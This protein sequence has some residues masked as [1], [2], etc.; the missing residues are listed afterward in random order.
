MNQ[1]IV[2]DI[3][4]DLIDHTNAALKNLK[5]VKLTEKESKNVASL[6]QN[7]ISKLTQN[8]LT[9]GVVGVMKAG[10]STFINSLIGKEILPSRTL[11]MT[12]IPTKIQ[13]KLISN[14]EVEYFFSLFDEY[15][16]F[17][18]WLSQ[19]TILDRIKSG[20]IAHKVDPALLDNLTSGSLRVVQTANSLINAQE[21]LFIVNDLAR[22]NSWYLNNYKDCPIDLLENI[23]NE[24]DIPTLYV[25]FNALKDVSLSNTAIALID[26]P[27]PDEAGQNMALANVLK[28]VLTNASAVYCVINGK[29]I[30]DL[31][32]EEL[33]RQ[34]NTYKNV[35]S[36]RLELIVNQKD[37]IDKGLCVEDVIL[38][39]RTFGDFDLKNKIH[40]L[41]SKSA[42]YCNLAIANADDVESNFE[43]YQSNSPKW[44]DE[45]SSLRGGSYLEDLEDELDEGKKLSKV[46]IKH[47]NRMHSKSGFDEFINNSLV[48]IYKKSSFDI[49][50][51]AIDTF[52]SKLD[53]DDSA[54]V[55]HSIR[56]QIH[57]FE[58]GKKE[59]SE[60]N[61]AMELN[62][63]KILE[64]RQKTHEL[65]DVE[66]KD[67]NYLAKEISSLII[68]GDDIGR[69]DKAHQCY[70]KIESII[71]TSSTNFSNESNAQSKL[72]SIKKQLS[73]SLESLN[74]ELN[75]ISKN[76]AEERISRIN[77]VISNDL[78][79]ILSTIK[80]T[81]EEVIDWSFDIPTIQEYTSSI[82]LEKIKVRKKEITKYYD[83]DV[84][85]VGFLSK[86]ATKI[87][88]QRKE[89]SDVHTVDVKMMAE[90]ISEHLDKLLRYGFNQGEAIANNYQNKLTD[91]SNTITN[92]IN[93]TLDL[94]EKDK[95]EISK[96]L[97]KLEEVNV[98]F[99]NYNT[100]LNKLKGNLSNVR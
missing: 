32:D 53:V 94:K 26:S 67:S 18:N 73:T 31:S 25:C 36:N 28:Q 6:F 4:L 80:Y 10:K 35:I 70:K 85:G 97:A 100:Y 23:G 98:I 19:S 99:K 63:K 7:E 9:I 17:A 51:S 1:E 3:R 8:L 83:R 89:V 92:V 38:S 20:D 82:P 45:F 91:Y 29:K 90:Q 16:N 42:L 81:S 57:A 30:D 39:N 88:G 84:L 27:G 78:E 96:E 93:N 79:I 48:E 43:T 86:F 15:Q 60:F 69:F 41:S 87:V 37:Q 54:S 52:L 62:I 47:A 77:Q 74:H 75:S 72:D 56:G 95:S 14:E 13:H 12:F 40:T 5:N 44:F 59:L 22:I 11:G 46:V 50:L 2:N 71:R 58:I 49:L 68:D 21:Q 64:L 66:L 33:R 34:I 76:Q 24:S 65:I 55:F 61:S